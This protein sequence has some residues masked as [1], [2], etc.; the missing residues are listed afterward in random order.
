MSTYL[1]SIYYI[2]EQIDRVFSVALDFFSKPEEVKT[3]YLKFP[4]GYEEKSSNGYIPF[5]REK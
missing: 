2:L 5:A 3:K 4:H 1:S